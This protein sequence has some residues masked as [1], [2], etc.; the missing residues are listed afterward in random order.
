MCVSFFYTVYF[1]FDSK[2]LFS[3]HG[4]EFIVILVTLSDVNKWKNR[5]IYFCCCNVLCDLDIIILLN[6]LDQCYFLIRCM[7]YSFARIFRQIFY[8]ERLKGVR[9]L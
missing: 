4:Y 2:Y 3:A 8:R 9:R 7:H 6:D 1:I 5:I